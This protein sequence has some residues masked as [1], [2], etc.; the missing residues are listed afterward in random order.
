MGAQVPIFSRAVRASATA[1]DVDD[2]LL[3]DIEFTFS[4]QSELSVATQDAAVDTIGHVCD[5]FLDC[6]ETL[7]DMDGLYVEMSYYVEGGAVPR[8]EPITLLSEHHTFFVGDHVAYRTDAGTEWLPSQ[9]ELNSSESIFNK[10][11]LVRGRI[12]SRQQQRYGGVPLPFD[13]E[14]EIWLSPPGGRSRHEELQEIIPC[15]TDDKCSICVQFMFSSGEDYQI[16]FANRVVPPLLSL[17]N[18][19]TRQ[20]RRKSHAQFSR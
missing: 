14:V 5:Q 1:G 13:P 6:N 8:C 4:V 20:N 11:L 2:V 19:T 18:D 16:N 10:M 3:T 15:D 9:K 7:I 12:K 17:W